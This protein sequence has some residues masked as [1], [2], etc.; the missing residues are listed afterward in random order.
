MHVSVVVNPL[1]GGRPVD[2]FNRHAVEVLL[3]RVAAC[4][5]ASV[6]LR[7]SDRPGGVR[8]CTESALAAGA[9]VVVGW[10]G[11]GT[12]NEVA[13]VL[14]GTRVALGIVPVGSG[15]GLAREL[16]I[17]RRPVEAL[18]LVCER[19]LAR[20]DVGRVDGRLFVNVAGFGFDAYVARR[21]NESG[22]ARGLVRYV[23]WTVSEVF[24]Y[25]PRHYTVTWDGGRFDGT[26]LFVVCANS[27]Q[28]GN[29]ARIA[30]Q[31]LIDDGC[32]DLV[33]ITPSTPLS[34][35][36]RAR[37]L[38]T[39]TIGRDPG[40]VVARVTEATVAGEGIDGHVDGETLPPR[41]SST[42][43]VWPGALDVCRGPIESRRP[44]HVRQS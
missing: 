7:V 29:G 4:A 24:R 37:R 44:S 38:F 3:A 43:Q 20:L 6:D 40:V 1:A 21:F 2:R 25:R 28:F 12:V 26:A 11:D 33:V 27:R 34:D 39:G 41:N 18:R 32:L 10:G 42:I 13:S 36:W 35:L 14:A 30:P 8:T 22:S 23:R 16:G 5:G 17:P 15:N 19:R 31:A 9:D